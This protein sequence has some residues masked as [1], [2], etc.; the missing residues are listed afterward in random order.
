[1]APTYTVGGSFAVTEILSGATW[2][3][4]SKA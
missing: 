3:V 1:L 4:A 2:I